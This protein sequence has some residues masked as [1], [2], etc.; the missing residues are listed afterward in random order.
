[1]TIDQSLKIAQMGF[2]ITMA[3]VAIL[4]YLK[5]KKTLLNSINTEYHKHVINAL[6]G[7]S[8]ELYSEFDKN[9]KTYWLN[10]TRIDEVVNEINKEFTKNKIAILASKKFGGGIRVLDLEDRLMTQIG[11][12]KSDPFLPQVIRQETLDLLENRLIVFNTSYCDVI[13]NY[14]QDLAKGKHIETL[15]SNSG[16]L[17]NKLNR[18]LY[19]QG[20]GISQIEDAVHDIRLN[21]KTYLD[22]FNPF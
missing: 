1:M 22:K 5:A 10:N 9:S 14:M 16:W 7:L 17:H 6:I 13:S 4:T 21:I 2:Y 19:E 12:Y 3:V 8:N 15:E 11:R 18:E 20:C